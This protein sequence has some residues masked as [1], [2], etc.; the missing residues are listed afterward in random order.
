MDKQRGKPVLI[1]FWDFCRVSSLRTLPYLRAW[2][3]RYAEAGLRV[4][5]VHVTTYEASRDEDAARAA[6][7]RLGSDWPVLLDHEGALGRSY[8][9]EGLSARYL[10]GAVPERGLVLRE[11]SYGEGGYR[12]TG[13]AIKAELGV[14]LEPLPPVR[15]EDD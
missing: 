15:P 3:D 12:G 2:H 4:V 1:E 8:D 13:R 5:G 14:S 9:N 6:I 10:W 7:A 11:C